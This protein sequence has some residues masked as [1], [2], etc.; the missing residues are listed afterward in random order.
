MKSKT[1]QIGDFLNNE[2]VKIAS[3]YYDRAK[4]GEFTFAKKFSEDVIAPNIEK[5]NEKLG[6][7]N[8]PLFLAYAVEYA[9]SIT[10]QN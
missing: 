9:F 3:D 1:I 4:N 10:S 5:I 6:Q 8:D 7:E 2:Q